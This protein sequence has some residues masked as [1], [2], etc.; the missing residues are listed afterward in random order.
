MLPAAVIDREIPGQQEVPLDGIL[1]GH[2]V[3]LLLTEG[4]DKTFGFAVAPGRVRPGSN[5]LEAKS[6][7]SLGKFA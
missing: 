6:L 7:A 1:E 5:V 3:R 2:R 4:L